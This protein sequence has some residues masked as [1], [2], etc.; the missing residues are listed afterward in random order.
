MIK[1]EDGVKVRT[2][3]GEELHA[4]VVLF[5]T[6]FLSFVDLLATLDLENVNIFHFQETA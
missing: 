3:K 1:T 2:D 4:D 5:A 6:G